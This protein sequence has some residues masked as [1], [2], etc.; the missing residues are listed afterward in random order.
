MQGVDI[1]YAAYCMII[2]AYIAKKASWI[3]AFQLFNSSKNHLV[4]EIL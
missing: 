3:V 4:N 1:A 2:W